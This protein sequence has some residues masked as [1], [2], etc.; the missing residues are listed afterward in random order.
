MNDK[1]KEAF[2]KFMG[3]NLPF[4]YYQYYSCPDIDAWQ[5]VCE[6]KQKEIDELNKTVEFF[7]SE[8]THYFE[9]LE[10]LQAENAKLKETISYLPKVAT[11]PYEKEMAKEIQKLQ[12]ENLKLKYALLEISQ[13]TRFVEG[14]ECSTNGAMIAAEVLKEVGNK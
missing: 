11:Q 2:E 12:A 6:Y 7:A 10:K 3:E 4:S 1:D 9:S 8:N 14:V 5:A 13:E